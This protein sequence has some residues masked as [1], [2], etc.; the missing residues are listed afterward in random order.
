MNNRKKTFKKKLVIA[1]VTLIL[2]SSFFSLIFNR[3]TTKIESIFKETFQTIEYY[4]IKSPLQYIEDL[5]DEY[6]AMKN[7]YQEN[8][9][10]KEALD[11]YSIVKFQNDALQNELD[12][13]KKLNEFTNI[14]TDYKVKKAVVTSRDIEGWNSKLLID[15]G[16]KDDIE[17]GMIV[18]TTEGMIG[19]IS[20]VSEFSSTVTL[21]TSEN[22]MAQVPIMIK[23]KDSED[24][25]YG[26]LTKYD[27]N[28]HQFVVDMLT[29]DEIDPEGEVLTSGTGGISPRSIVVGKVSEI[30]V[31]T[32]RLSPQVKV[33]PSASFDDLKYVMVLQRGDS[34]E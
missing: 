13:L 17:E 10:L 15:V 11:D 9:L 4:L 12:E 28:T 2:T 5:K 19:K 31:P 33:T 25:A 8:Q 7:V 23:K 27:V 30:T 16:S 26:V 34:N 24:Y 14:P 22:Y 18:I 29:D 1:I 32:D 3:K 20:S 6:V 21:L